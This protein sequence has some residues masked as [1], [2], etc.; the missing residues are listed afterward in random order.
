[1][2]I[3]RHARSRMKLYKISAEDLL[4]TISEPELKEL[5]ASYT[6]A[7]RAFDRNYGGYPLKVV[8]DEENSLIVTV[9]PLKRKNWSKA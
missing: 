2:K 1:M 6:V 3:S 7:V 9:Y 5:E 4:L 8:Y